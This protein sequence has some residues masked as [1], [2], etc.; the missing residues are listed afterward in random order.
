MNMLE[1][2]AALARA[3]EVDRQT[4]KGF[5]GLAGNYPIVGNICIKGC[6]QGREGSDA[7]AKAMML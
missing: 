4:R 6:M 7:M 2:N 5:E 1:K 3:G